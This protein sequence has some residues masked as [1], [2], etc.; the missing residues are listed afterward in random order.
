MIIALGLDIFYIFIFAL[1][2]FYKENCNLDFFRL[3]LAHHWRIIMKIIKKALAFTLTA[4]VGVSAFAFDPAALASTLNAKS[5]QISA[6]LDDFAKQLSI[7]VPQAATQQN[8]WADA[9]IGKLFPSVVPHFGGGLNM[10]LT[11]INTSGLKK[12]IESLGLSDIDIKNDY[13]FPVFTAD[14]RVG[15]VL[16]PFDAGIAVM[17]TGKLSTSKFGADL[18]VDLLTIGADVRYAMFE[19]GLVMPKLSI[20]AGY[21][22]NQ[23]TFGVDSDYAKA[24]VDYKVHTMYAQAQLSKKFLFVTPFIGLRGL[25]S[26]SNNEWNWEYKSTYATQI[27]NAATLASIPVPK[28]KDNGAYTTSNFDFNAIQPQ[29]FAGVGVNFLII[30][31]TLSITADLRNIKDD[32]LWSGAASLRLSI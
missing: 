5:G 11:H 10:G 9:Y 7:S 31:F 8:V 16:L 27:A 12:A 3:E 29:V 28:L 22:Y 6:G 17:K 1:I 4:F 23:G 25:V 30:D 21:F 32:G 13:Y 26:K 14:L 18:D 15:G 20:G 2:I 24:T 19:G